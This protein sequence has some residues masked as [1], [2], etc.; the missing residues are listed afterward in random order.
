MVR[1][2]VNILKIVNPIFDTP[3]KKQVE[4]L[5]EKCW[6]DNGLKIDRCINASRKIYDAM[7]NPKAK[8]KTVYAYTCDVKR[9]RY[10][11]PKKRQGTHGNSR[12][13]FCKVTPDLR[14]ELFTEEEEQIKKELMQK[15]LSTR[16]EQVIDM[17]AAKQSYE[18][19][20][21]TL[22]EYQEIVDT[23]LATDIGWDAFVFNFE[24]AIGCRTDFATLVED[25][26]WIEEAPFELR[27]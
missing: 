5:F 7:H 27:D 8:E 24:Q 1:G 17:R 26:A 11:V 22:Q 21:I 15:Y 6:G 3:A 9:T 20:E 12:W 25:R 19:N 18:S 14:Y 4:N 10:G 16:E 23:I 13:V 2:G